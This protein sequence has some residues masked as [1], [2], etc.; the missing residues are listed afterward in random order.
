MDFRGHA[1][2]SVP[3]GWGYLVKA[4]KMGVHGE[5]RS[6]RTVFSSHHPQASAKNLGK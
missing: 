6:S 3:P 5:N 4:K 2:L 1:A